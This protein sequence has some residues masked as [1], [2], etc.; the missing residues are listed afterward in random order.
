M[1]PSITP[2]TKPWLLLPAA[3]A[4]MAAAGAASAQSTVPATFYDCQTRDTS[5]RYTAAAGTGGPSVL[6]RVGKQVIKKT[7]AE[8]FVQ[9]NVMGSLVTVQLDSVP[10]SH[11]NSLSLVAPDFNVPLIVTKAPGSFLSTLVRTTSFTSVGGPGLVQGP[12]QQSSTEALLC[13]ASAPETIAT[14]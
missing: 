12:L 9:R 8:M 13:T 5:V 7:G 1:T 4:L 2:R 10:D 3:A 6:I 14:E 11:T